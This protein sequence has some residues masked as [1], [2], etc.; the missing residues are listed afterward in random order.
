MIFCDRNDAH[1]DE[2]EDGLLPAPAPVRMADEFNNNKRDVTPGRCLEAM[3]NLSR[4]DAV[5]MFVKNYTNINVRHSKG[6]TGWVRR[7][8]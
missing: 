8:N 1:N 3:I 2:A 4:R 7:A 5:I 6:N